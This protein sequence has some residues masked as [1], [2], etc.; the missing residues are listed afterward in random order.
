VARPLGCILLFRIEMA[1]PRIVAA[2][3]W[4]LNGGG[5]R[6]PVVPTPRF[7]P[8]R[9]EDVGK[10]LPAKLLFLTDSGAS[11]VGDR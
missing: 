6:R 10:R 1:M 9:S 7:G 5:V 3:T 2:T 8:D 4:G 11:M